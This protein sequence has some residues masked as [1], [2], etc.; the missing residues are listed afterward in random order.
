MLKTAFA[1]LA[2][3]NL[4]IAI[5]ATCQTALY[6]SIHNV[7]LNKELL[8]FTFF[9]TVIVYLFAVGYPKKNNINHADNRIAWLSKNRNAMHFLMMI[10]I[11]SCIILI[12]YLDHQF[13]IITLAIFALMYNLKFKFF[14]GFRAMPMFKIISIAFVWIMVCNVY[15]LLLYDIHFDFIEF[16]RISLKFIWIVALTIPFDIR[17]VFNDQKQNLITIPS[18]IGTDNSYYLTYLLFSIVCVIQVFTFGLC[19]ESLVVLTSSLLAVLF[20][21]NSKR[22]V[23]DF[24]YLI[25]LDGLMILQFLQ[26]YI[27]NIL[28]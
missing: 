8:A 21:I 23:S 16:I 28:I 1:Y 12:N 7:S 26:F 19:N 22:R 20:I 3:S 27:I 4:F 5:A 25:K 18:L 14:N 9:A 24:D 11:I 2:Y 17:D 10:S 6:L 13:E 15:P